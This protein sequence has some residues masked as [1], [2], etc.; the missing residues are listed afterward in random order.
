VKKKILIAMFVS[1]LFLLA[2]TI[3]SMAA[4]T[5]G[6]FSQIPAYYDGGLFTI[7]FQE[8]PPG[9]EA[10]ALMH[11]KSVNHIYRS[12]QA[13]ACGTPVTSVI[14][15]LPGPGEGPGFNPLW[16]EVQIHYLGGCG[17]VVQFTSDNDI[18][19]QV[20]VTIALTYTTEVYTCSVVGP[21]PK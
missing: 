14:D 17:S 10:A 4:S 8:L 19:P 12:D 5:N 6:K 7:T 20:G 18:L 21:G 11:N 9:G 16:Q 13:E 15:A 3:P 1:V 2:A